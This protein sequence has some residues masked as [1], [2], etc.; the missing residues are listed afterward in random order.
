MAVHVEER[1]VPMASVVTISLNPVV[2]TP[3]WSKESG[4]MLIRHLL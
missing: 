4:L 2:D 3:L 1:K